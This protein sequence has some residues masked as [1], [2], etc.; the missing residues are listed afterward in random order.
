MSGLSYAAVVSLTLNQYYDI[1]TGNKG[2]NNASMDFYCSRANAA[3]SAH[4]ITAANRATI[5]VKNVA[6]NTSSAVGYKWDKSAHDLGTGYNWIKTS[7][8]NY[9]KIYSGSATDGTCEFNDVVGF[10]LGKYPYFPFN[11]TN[12][13]Q[14]YQ[15][16]TLQVND[17]LSFVFNMGDLGWYADN[18][19]SYLTFNPLNYPIGFD[20]YY[21]TLANIFIPINKGWQF[22][23]Q[24]PNP[25]CDPTLSSSNQFSKLAVYSTGTFLTSNITTML[26]NNPYQ[27]IEWNSSFNNVYGVF[28]LIENRYD[29]GDSASARH[30][31]RF[32]FASYNLSSYDVVTGVSHT[33]QIPQPNQNVTVTFYSGQNNNGAVFWR[34]RNLTG[35]LSYSMWLS[36][37]QSTSSTFHSIIINSAFILDNKFYQYYVTSGTNVN[38]N[39]DNFYNFTVGAFGQIGGDTG[40]VLPTAINRLEASGFCSGST[41][42]YIFGFFVTAFVAVI[43]FFYGGVRLGATMTAAAITVF[44]VIGLLPWF[45]LIPI[46]L[47]VVIYIMLHLNLFGGNNG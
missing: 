42:V 14:S 23:I 45:M 33:P 15:F 4:Q 11:A 18:D 31:I 34:Y 39:S 19:S 10:Y 40:S 43:S 2:T 17:T 26:T 44:A 36:N 47:Y 24:C 7:Q 32:S 20:V 38:N 35:D 22:L 1:E 5:A 28:S 6:L 16:N 46:V 3:G 30:D 21:E 41:C 27:Y 12:S 37:I 25:V 8:G 13:F 9:S 29:L